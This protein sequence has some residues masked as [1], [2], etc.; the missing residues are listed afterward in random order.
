MTRISV[1]MCTFNGG[2]FLDAQLDSLARQTLK[3]IEL[4]VCDDGSSDDTQSRV[5]QF[6]E[7]APFAVRWISNPSRL[8]YR[9]NFMTA[10]RQC[11]GDLIAFCDQDDV[12]CPDKLERAAVPFASPDVMLSYHRVSLIDQDGSRLGDYDDRAPRTNPVEYP[13]CDPWLFGLGFTLTF[14]RKLCL[15]EALWPLSR[16]FYDRE[17]NA[18]HDQWFFFLALAHGK[19]VYIDAT[20]ALYRQHDHNLF[21]AGLELGSGS[22]TYQER[23]ALRHDRNLNHAAACESNVAILTQIVGTVDAAQV[24]KVEQMIDR[25]HV[26]GRMFR[27][28]GN[29]AERH[30]L[31]R[32]L[33][34]LWRLRSLGSYGKGEPW[35]FERRDPL[36]DLITCI[37]SQRSPNRI[38]PS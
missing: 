37:V 12:W 9:A 18:A 5:R 7:T 25:F 13:D 29:L 16:D 20:L 38:E 30:S 26:L 21:G 31:A 28:S 1:A 33:H 3:P 4:V 34:D 22:S 24:T 10:A 14:R 35:S 23:M 32:K 8:G 15:A 27:L 19:I 36:R 6:A 17:Q 2:R 11:A